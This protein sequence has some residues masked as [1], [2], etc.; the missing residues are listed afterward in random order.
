MKPDFSTVC[1]S[2]DSELVFSDSLVN[3]PVTDYTPSEG[4]TFTVIDEAV[5]ISDFPNV[6]FKNLCEG[7]SETVGLENVITNP[8]TIYPNPTESVL[9]IKML[10]KQS[11]AYIISDISGRK[12]LTGITNNQLDISNL[13][14]GLYTLQLQ[15]KK[16]PNHLK[17]IKN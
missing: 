13:K 15:G 6:Q 5:G 7:C 17:F 1:D 16:H 3:Y 2:L 12:I 14:P 4:V 11:T 10:G 9:N 8:I